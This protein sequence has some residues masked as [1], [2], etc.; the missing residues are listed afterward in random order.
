MNTRSEIEQ[1]FYDYNRTEF[2]GWKWGKSDPVHGTKPEK[3]AKL[4]NGNIIKPS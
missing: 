3:F 4:I 1:A 2:G